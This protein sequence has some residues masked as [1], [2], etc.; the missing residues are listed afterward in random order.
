VTTYLD[1]SVI[2]RWVLAQN[3]AIARPDAQTHVVTSRLTTVEALRTL[4]RLRRQN[5][6]SEADYAYRHGVVVRLF[7]RIDRV[8]L[9]A[10]VPGTKRSGSRHTISSSVLRRAPPAST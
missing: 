3:N 2:L 6:L 1:T 9:Y 8:H 10:A 7:D 4:D 5:Q